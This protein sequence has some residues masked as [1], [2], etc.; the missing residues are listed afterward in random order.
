MKLYILPSLLLLFS[1]VACQQEKEETKA[2][3][4]NIIYIL[5][6]DLGYGEL[7]V[8]G[9]SLIETPHID[10]LA[11]ES[12]FFEHPF[13][14]VPM[15]LPS[16]CSMFTGLIPPAHGVHEN[17]TANLPPSALTLPEILQQHGYATYGIVSAIVLK[18]ERG[19]NQGFDKYDD[20]IDSG[21][22]DV[23]LGAHEAERN[24]QETTARALE[25]LS[26]HAQK[27]KFM[28]IHYLPLQFGP[29]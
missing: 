6:D 24:G 23:P 2:V 13:A 18:A 22:G 28:F 15:T 21:D 29:R 25:W 19:L 12:L 10:A 11:K 20:A 16:H 9:Q 4:P 17:T 26:G 5:A 1:L 8:Y 14:T 27:K 7:G 3:T